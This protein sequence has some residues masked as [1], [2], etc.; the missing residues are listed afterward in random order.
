MIKRYLPKSE[1]SRNVLTLMT[2]TTLAQAIPVAISPIL[3]RL[4]TPEEFG[5]LALYLSIVGI[6]SVLATGRYEM[7]ILLPKKNRDAYHL[8]VLAL[9]LNLIFTALLLLF[10][11]IFGAV[12][13]L[14]SLGTVFI[15]V[16]IA[17]LLIGTVNGVSRLLNR[18][19]RYSLLS[20]A[21]MIQA[22]ANGTASLSFGL[23]GF[24]A[25]ALIVA[26][27][28]GMLFSLF[29]TRSALRMKTVSPEISISSLGQVAKKYKNFPAFQMPHAF[30][31]AL[32]SHMPVLLFSLFFL[33]DT[34]GLYS[35]STQIVLVPLIIIST[36]LAQVFNRHA[37]QLLSD[38]ASIYLFTL[39]TIRRVLK[40]T[41]PAFLIVVAFAPWLFATLFG[42]P[43]REAGVY[44][45]ILSP[46]LFMVFIVSA[47]SYI[48]NLL[49][50]Q[51]KAL[52][53]E[54][55]Y[56]ALRFSSLMIGVLFN[57][58]YLALA[59]FSLSGFIMLSYNL[60]WIL[61]LAK[62]GA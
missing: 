29:F 39:Q 55:I 34:A 48:P 49:G 24:S 12:S 15:F 17:V 26:H 16:P 41:A 38:G 9:L 44:T 21:K 43:W 18:E 1:F 19:E 57:E 6:L 53:L 58:I 33:S 11:L 42:G 2:G 51:K 30:L 50:R 7:A 36:S 25:K 35:L 60:R 8:F 56:T 45:Q 4:Y 13:D 22:S 3:T 59:L 28:L 52:L 40:T 31:N 27:M 61:H 47:V 14:S 32:S 62:G 20:R 10:Y 5:V 37:A 46:W 23:I 54:L